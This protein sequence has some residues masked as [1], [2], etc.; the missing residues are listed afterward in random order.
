MA[1][2]LEPG[3]HGTTF[4]GNPLASAAART[5]LD[6][7]DQPAF[8]ADVKEKGQYFMDRIRNLNKESVQDVRGLG[9]M[10][11][12]QVGADKVSEYLAA[13]QK[14]GVLALKAGTDTIR[15]LPPLIITKE[16][17]DQAVAAMDDVFE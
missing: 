12:I 5:V 7:V 9:L 3:D 6:I 2:V 10:I 17:I 13:L 1:D 4:G 15:L 14:K 11:G 8:L 16:E